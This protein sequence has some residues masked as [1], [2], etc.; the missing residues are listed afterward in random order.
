M[1]TT[2][3]ASP[4]AKPDQAYLHRLDDVAFQPIFIMGDHRSG[5]T[6]LYQL[7]ELSKS[8][9]PITTYHIIMYDELLANHIA[10]QTAA[11]KQRLS[12]RFD[13]L[14][15]TDRKI[16]GVQVTPDLTEEY[17]FMLH[18]AGQRPHITPANLDFFT[19]VCRKVQF[20]SDPDKPLLLKNPWDFFMNFAY[21]K[22]CFPQ[23]RFIFL[24]RHPTRI[25]NSQMKAM[26]SVFAQR[27]DYI[28]LIAEW[29]APTWDNPLRLAMSRFVFSSHLDMGYRLA[30]THVWRA[31][32]YLLREMPAIPPSD[33]ISVRYEDLC[34]TP[35]QTIGS[36]M[37]FLKL[38][39]Q[40]ALDYETFINVRQSPLLPEVEKRKHKIARQFAAYYE[41]FGYEVEGADY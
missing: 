19:E 32:R 41:K 16:D 1:T 18:G 24:S 6:L 13:A 12:Q 5:T 37:D 9:N 26:R 3:I 20:I 33:Y 2:N 30:W 10:G 35:N 40:V 34:Q 27:N 11:A 23:S 39:P 36:I 29:Y 31:I 22:R 21:V 38:Q 8:F 28:A 7:L 25:I 17:G 15:L 4:T 14:G